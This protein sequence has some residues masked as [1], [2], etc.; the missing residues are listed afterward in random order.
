LRKIIF[1]SVV[2]LIVL[3]GCSVL[4][5]SS[6][7][8]GE[9]VKEINDENSIGSVIRNNISNENFYIQKAEIKVNQDN[10]SA[11]FIADIKFKKP[12]TL[13]ISVRSKAGIV[14]GRAF[15]TKDTILLNDRINKKLLIG[16]PEII[17]A[18]YGIDPIFIFAVLGDII[19]DEKELKESLE[20]K[21]G[22]FRKEFEIN[23]KSV[24]YTIDC[25]K[26]KALTAYFE[27]DI[28]TG[29]ITIDY[30]NI[31]ISDRI[32]YPQR[33]EITDDLRSLNIIVEIKKIES[34]WDGKIE[35]VR[36]SGYKV[37][38]IR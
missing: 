35:F 2:F 13:L 36:G 12:D 38:K 7:T 24:E 11:R 33:I 20:C 1:I 37:V 29:N 17:A 22:I 23:N 27:G 9:T 32:R 25:G 34:P 5:K 10:I 8:A 14:A 28:K 3:S 15:I 31:M 19:V 4:R 16:N 18:K 6:S 30:S 26:K 21:K